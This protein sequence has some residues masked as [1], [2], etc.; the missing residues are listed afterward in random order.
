VVRA[1][2]PYTGQRLH[3]QMGEK[4]VDVKDLAPAKG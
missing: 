2:S 4:P 3:L 1:H